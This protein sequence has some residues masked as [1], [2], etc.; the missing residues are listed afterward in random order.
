MWWIIYDE[1]ACGEQISDKE[2]Y[3]ELAYQQETFDRSNRVF[4]AES[5]AD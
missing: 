4:E 1:S 3:G 5:G 2:T